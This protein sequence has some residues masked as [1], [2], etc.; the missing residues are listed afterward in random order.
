MGSFSK[1]K[2]RDK[3]E[4]EQHKNKESFVE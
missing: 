2:M 3:Y 1:F 4:T